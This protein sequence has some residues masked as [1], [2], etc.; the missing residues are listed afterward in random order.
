MSLLVSIVFFASCEKVINVDINN[1][2]PRIV[3]EGI[4]TDEPGLVS[5]TVYLSKTNNFSSE[6]KR[7]P[8][9]NAV[10][11]VSDVTAGTNDTLLQIQPGEY[12]TQNT[13]GISGHTYQLSAIVD[14]K[15]YTANTTMPDAVKFDSLYT[16]DFNFF[17]SK[18]TQAIPVFTDP[19]GIKN[20]YRF[21][22]QVNDSMDKELQAWDDRLSDGKTNSRP[23]NIN[24]QDWLNGSDTLTIT[25]DC[26]D[27]ACFD[28]FNTLENASGNGQTPANPISNI[29]G[30]GLGYFAAITKRKKTIILP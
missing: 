19:A 24:N 14:G 4:I 8:V 20:Y 12:L 2:T 6:N 22:V 13:F 16:Q 17:G 25:M 11:V 28:F 7:T 9:T 1:A 29:S 30:D 3:I 26:T 18:F 5:H 21:A 27:K 15:T 10:I 23:L